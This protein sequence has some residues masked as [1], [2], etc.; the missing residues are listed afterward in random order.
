MTTMRKLMIAAAVGLACVLTPA[1]YAQAADDDGYGD[2]YQTGD[3][4]RIR[5][6]D[7]GA[8]IIRAD[9]ER[10]EHDRAGVNAPIFPGDALRTGSGERV[11][12]QLSGGSVIRVDEG[13]E[14]LFQSL[15][16]SSAKYED[17]VVLALRGGAIRVL[18]QVPE[19]DEF[20]V[21]TRDASVYLLGN[22]EFRVEAD[23]RGTGVA[24]LRGVAEV[25]GDETSVLVRGG[26][27]TF[28]VDGSAPDAPRSYSALRG[29]E[30]DRWCDSRD[31]TYRAHERYDDDDYQDE[32][33]YEVR[34]YYGELSGYGRWVMTSDY[35]RVWVPAGVAPSWRPY[36]DG[37]WAYG[38]GGY[39]WVS[40][41][42]WG[43][44][45]YHYG[46]WQWVVGNGWCWIPGR[47]F[48]GAWVSWSWGS[49]YLGWAPL[50]F[51]GRPC[52]TGGHYYSGYYDPSCWTF[53]NYSNIHVTN[54]RRYAVPI[55][56]V[57]NDLRRATV[58]A[59]PPRIDPRRIAQSKDW[60]DR[61]LRQVSED[62]RAR[63]A[64]IDATHRPERRLRDV[65]DR[66]YE[67]SA[68]ARRGT[69][70]IP[71]PQDRQ[72]TTPL[73]GTPRTRLPQA[74]SP[75]GSI[76]TPGVGGQRGPG[77]GR[78]RRILDDPRV[79]SRPAPR[80]DQGAARRGNDTRDDV[81]QLYQRM[82]RPR[83]TRGQDAAPQRRDDSLV[84]P[85]RDAPQ[86]RSQADVPRTRQPE[87]RRDAPQQSRPQAQA[88]SPRQPEWRRDAPADR[89]P[90][91]Q[92][93]R[94]ERRIEPRQAPGRIE[95]RGNPQ[96]PRMQ[97][98]PQRQ[99]PQ[100]RGN[101]GNGSG[102]AK[103]RGHDKH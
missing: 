101:G 67:R 97:A 25:V 58:V 27:R 74:R 89:A 37:Y 86:Q 8:S 92:A 21:D 15:P 20:R 62:R 52:W 91:Y 93:P 57:G 63:L 66:L 5:Y 7:G 59:R 76:V 98:A 32:I 29:D 12:I 9:G 81:R 42:P 54:V 22:G 34:P 64:P 36:S 10:D 39:F 72:R 87:W 61:A 18:S 73:P 33:P 6:S 99:A 30:F 45:P 3:Y 26:N 65:Q 14:V 96:Q 23:D 16:D 38:P 11:E 19:K 69:D 55:G 82:S 75:Q 103:P 31:D 50:D 79:Q 56:T 94:G 68:Q 2:G 84:T 49:L 88:P 90:S 43:W 80:D 95:P 44:A 60:R 78:P 17:N 100:P 102:Q 71:A 53:V 35:G 24:S 4:G 41:E 47:V 85:R 46:N 83:E 77:A 1:A 40:Y 51:W 13:T 28:V 70:R 48:A